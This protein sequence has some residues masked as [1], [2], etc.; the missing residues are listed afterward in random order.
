M[1]P[2]PRQAVV[3]IH[4]VG[5]QRPMETLRGFVAAIAGRRAALS[6]PDRISS[7][8]E[9]HRMAVPGKAE[10]WQPGQPVSTDFYELYW[11]HLMTGTSWNHV[12]AWVRT[13]MLRSPVNVPSRLLVL[14]IVSW[15]VGIGVVVAALAGSWRPSFSSWWL[16]AVAAAAVTVAK[17]SGF[18]FGLQY[19]GDAAR[20][21]SPTPPN[22]G[23][24]HAIRSAA[25]DLLNGL[26]DDPTWRRY[27]RI[28][29]VGHSLGSVIGYDALTHVWQQRHH[30]VAG[31]RWAP[32]P[33]HTR[34]TELL[35]GGEPL[36]VDDARILQAG[37]WREQRE[38]G[39]QW[40]IT[41]FVTLGSPLAHAP[42]LMAKD[43]AEFKERVHDREFPCCPPTR[44]DSRDEEYG[45]SLLE[46]TPRGASG[47]CKLL[48]HAA[49]FAC[50]R[51]TNLF[52]RG[53]YVGGTLRH[54]GSWIK[55]HLTAVFPKARRVGE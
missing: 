48:H 43:V 9:L 42:F 27:H 3:I 25:I 6:K 54:F 4:G 2:R 45:H 7:T 36:N 10:D 19:V 15:V 21:L 29:V 35:N 20:Y 28:V 5:E 24:R 23:V 51:W 22:V 16:A 50:T 38:I 52:F 34:L 39:V 33:N 8:L 18:Y 53:D 49:P 44:E 47:A 1:S 30:P 31:Q 40:K 41:D 55:E 37:V 17:S 12:A 32:Q 13:L 46:L 11:A 14:W 26:H